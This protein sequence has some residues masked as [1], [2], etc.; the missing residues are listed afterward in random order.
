MSSKRS[1]Q[2][3]DTTV[4]G[5]FVKNQQPPPGEYLFG[6]TLALVLTGPSTASRYLAALAPASFDACH[7]SLRN[8]GATIGT[9]QLLGEVKSQILLDLAQ[10]QVMTRV[11]AAPKAAA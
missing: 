3:V 5:A 7:A 6:R 4:T 11:L 9:E 8:V 10:E 2:Y 1:A